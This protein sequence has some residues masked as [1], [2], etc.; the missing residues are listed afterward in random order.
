MLKKDFYVCP[1][2]KNILVKALNFY[3]NMYKKKVHGDKIQFLLVAFCKTHDE[4]YSVM[5]EH[6][7]L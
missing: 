2:E 1:N 3:L 6:N 5:D 4:L 7:K